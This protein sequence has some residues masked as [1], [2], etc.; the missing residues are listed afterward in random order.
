MFGSAR[1]LFPAGMQGGHVVQVDEL[2]LV[3]AHQVV[4]LPAEKVL[5][6]RRDVAQHPVL[7]GH[8]VDVR[9]R[10]HQRLVV[11]LTVRMGHRQFCNAQ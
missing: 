7:A 3:P 4:G 1:Q 5:T 10:E 8:G 2:V 6:A 11:D 9:R